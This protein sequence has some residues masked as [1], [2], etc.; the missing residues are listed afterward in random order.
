VR[1]ALAVTLLV[2]FYLLMIGTA[3]AL[4]AVPI[5]WIA[6]TGRVSILLLLFW[7]ASALLLVGTAE[8]RARPFRPRGR[9]LSHDDAPR[10]FDLLHAIAQRSGV[11]APDQVFLTALPEAAVTQTGGLLRRGSRVL[12]LGLPLLD[13][14]TI[15][16]LQAVLAHEYGHFA[17]GDT[18]LLRLASRAHDLFATTVGA[19]RPGPFQEAP[20]SG[21][22]LAVVGGQALAGGIAQIYGRL[23]FL[24]SLGM[25]RREELAADRLAADVAGRDA[26]ISA[27]ERMPELETHHAY[28]ANDVARAAKRGVMPS[29]LLAGFQV[30]RARFFEGAGGREH[31]SARM[32]GPTSPFDTHPSLPDR[33]RALRALPPPP[34]R[35]V[36][37][38]DGGGDAD[39]GSP[40]RGGHP[41]RAIELLADTEEAH[42]WLTLETQASVMHVSGLRTMAWAEIA[43]SVYA[44]EMREA[45]RRAA[46]ALHP[47]FPEARTLPAMFAS[48]VRALDQGGVEAVAAALEPAIAA[49]PPRAAARA[50]SAVL[51]TA[52]SALFLGALLERGAT[53]NPG[54]GEGRPQLVFEG[55][56]LDAAGLAAR[57]MQ[58]SEAR[59]DLVRWAERLGT[60]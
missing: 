11:D 45:A 19:S 2:G 9:P 58:E 23:Y 31:L 37:D 4:A 12:V 46:A 54:L 26:M 3:L 32:S 30:F 10:L 28:L 27:L 1:A 8:A 48:V 36:T 52:L 47:L 29:D 21:L 40:Y 13:A 20:R 7:F 50:C 53:V 18:R 24:L 5:V 41:D 51:G 33:I 57:A 15:P 16:E 35:G 39:T 25:S 59:S 14:L 56:P 6:L 42:E 22:G 17:G 43:S 55:R 60:T 49:L 34:E 44:P 38:R